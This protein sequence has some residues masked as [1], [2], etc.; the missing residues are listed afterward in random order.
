VVGGNKKGKR[1]QE[2]AMGTGKIIFLT[3]RKR[4]RPFDVWIKKA[5]PNSPIPD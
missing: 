3:V 2:G 1:A 4:K 5:E